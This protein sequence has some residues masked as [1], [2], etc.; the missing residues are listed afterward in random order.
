MKKILTGIL[1]GLCLLLLPL[2]IGF[3]EE[4]NTEILNKKPTPEE[5][6]IREKDLEDLTVTQRDLRIEL[7]LEGGYHLWIKKKPGMGSVLITETTEDPARKVA[8]YAYRAKSY[9]P[10]NGDEIRILNGQ[11]LLPGPGRYF[12][13][14]STPEPDEVFGLAFHIFIPYVLEY[15]YPW[16]RQGEMEVVDGTFLNIRAFAKPHAD[17]TGPFK[18]NPFVF[19]IFQRSIPLPKIEKIM[20]DVKVEFSKITEETKGE[21]F[22]STGEKDMIDKIAAIIDKQKGRTLDMVITLDTTQSMEDDIPHIRKLLVPMVAERIKG[23]DTVR[24]GLT[25]YRDY[26]EEYLTRSLPFTSD[27]NQLQRM[28]DSVR[29]AGGRDIPEAVHEGI[30]A[31]IHNYKW[32]A[33]SRVIIVIGDAPPHPIPRGK[34]T[35]EMVKKDAEEKKILVY[36]IILPH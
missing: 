7:S 2:P 34:I 25:L 30:Y 31:A 12:L 10:Y 1:F 35:E 14:D 20:P 3:T 26:M 13:V 4:P 6:S 32:E 22:E 28:V 8:S 17:Y 33:E 9:N 23:F 19:R 18:D 5:G 15:G 24:I 21:T 36:T 29:V 27:L 16:S 11:T